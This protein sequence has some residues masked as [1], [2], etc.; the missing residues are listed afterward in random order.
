LGNESNI[1]EEHTTSTLRVEIDF[2]P[3]DGGSIF[4]WN[5]AIHLQEYMASQCRMP[6]IKK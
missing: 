1:L 6:A 4:L 3:E 2:I 5:G